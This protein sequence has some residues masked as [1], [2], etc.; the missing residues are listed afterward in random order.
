MHNATMINIF[1]SDNNNIACMERQSCQ[2]MTTS[3]CIIS[4]FESMITKSIV[5]NHAF[6]TFLTFS[7]INSPAYVSS[8]II[9]NILRIGN[10]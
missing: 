9:S 4:K 8:I 2:I 7:R 6:S 3:T 10:I 1:I 5:T